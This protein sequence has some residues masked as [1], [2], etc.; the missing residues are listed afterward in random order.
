MGARR[1]ERREVHPL[2]GRPPRLLA[3]LPAGRVERRL[4]VG[5]RSGRHLERPV[6]HR[7]AV[8]PDEQELVVLGDGRDEDRPRNA[9]VR[10]LDVTAV[11]PQGVAENRAPR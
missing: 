3:E 6:A 9:E 5:A 7:V 1:E 2:D 8:L 4:T 11:D 10:V